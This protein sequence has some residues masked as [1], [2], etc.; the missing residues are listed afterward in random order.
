ML[1]GGLLAG[2]FRTGGRKEY[3]LVANAGRELDCF[4][5]EGKGLSSTGPEMIG[6]R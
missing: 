1:T 3:I 4:L 2:V 5:S 6:L